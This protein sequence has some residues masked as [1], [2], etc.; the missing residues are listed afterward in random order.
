MF[1]KIYNKQSGVMVDKVWYT[2]ETQWHVVYDFESEN[3]DFDIIVE[4]DSED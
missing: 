2:S 3:H 1:W 4:A